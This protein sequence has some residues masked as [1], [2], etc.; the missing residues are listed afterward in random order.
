MCKEIYLTY[1]IYMARSL[2]TTTCDRVEKKDGN[3]DINNF[4]KALKEIE[5]TMTS[6]YVNE[7]I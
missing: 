6:F 4:Y 3:H 7:K 1:K 2:H 5:E